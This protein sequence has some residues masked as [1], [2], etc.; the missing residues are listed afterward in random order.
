MKAVAVIPARY[1]STRFP[2]KPLVAETGQPLVQHVVARAAQA[3][4]VSRIIVATDDNR[5]FA[6][7]R[8][9]GGEAV[10]TR[11]DHPSGTDRIVEA[12]GGLT[13]DLVLNIQGDEPEIDPNHLDG[14]IELM[15]ADPQAEVGTLACPFAVIPGSDPR[16]PN[17][18]KVV[19]DVRGRA[20]YFSRSLIPH[21]RGFETSGRV[22]QAAPYLLH[23]GVYAY[24]PAF[25]TSLAGLAPTPLERTEQLEQLR[26]LEHGHKIAVRVVESAAKG[27]DTPEDYAAFVKRYCGSAPPADRHTTGHGV[28]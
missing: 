13:A 20:I 10:M 15:E 7:V 23:V 4:R 5:I 21:P 24:R 2:G 1:A 3:R 6:A 25:L 26:W 27:I 28:A 8:S 9:F 12:A 19:L 16:D 18:V 22:H 11:P 14:L 17:A